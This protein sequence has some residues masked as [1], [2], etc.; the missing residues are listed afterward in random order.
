[1]NLGSRNSLADVLTGLWTQHAI[2]GVDGAYG[3]ARGR[4]AIGK[5]NDLYLILPGNKTP[6]LSILKATKEHKY[7]K[8]EL[9]WRG[10]GFP[11]TEPQ[12]D[13][14]RLDKENMLSIYTRKYAEGSEGK[15]NVVVVDFQL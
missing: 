2:P 1:M 12:V 6:A 7:S 13:I 10:D 11:P 14:S 8:Y 3:G 4:L 15:K 5:N 9:V